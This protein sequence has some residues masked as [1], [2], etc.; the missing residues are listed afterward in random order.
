MYYENS[1]KVTMKNK[2]VATTALE[3]LKTRLTS[4]FECASSYKKNPFKQMAQELFV[5]GKTIMLPE[6]FGCMVPEDA[7]SVQFDLLQYL[8]E[9]LN[10]DFSCQIYNYSDCSEAE[11]TANY[12]NGTLTIKSVFYPNG[13]CDCFC[14][15]EC[16]EEVVFVREYDESKTYI[17][18]YCG[19]E[20]DFTDWAPITTEK[21]IKII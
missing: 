17:C 7:E 14:C 9:D 5:K 12:Q 19:E 20:L 21:T 3:I 16:D 1:M 11:I 13:Y 4:D 15:G 10:E 8:A 2:K 18:P 6:D